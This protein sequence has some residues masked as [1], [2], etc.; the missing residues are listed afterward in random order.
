MASAY[1]SNTQHIDFESVLAMDDPEELKQQAVA[2]HIRWDRPCFSILFEGRLTSHCVIPAYTI[3]EVSRQRQYDD[4]LLSSLSV[5]GPFYRVSPRQSPVFSLR[6]SQFCTVFIDYSLFSRL[7]TEDI[8]HFVGSIALERTAL[9]SV[10][11][12]T[13]SADNQHVQLPSSLVFD[14][15][16]VQIEQSAAFAVTDEHMDID[17]SDDSS[18]HFDD[19]DA[20]AASISLPTSPIPD[21]TEDLNQLRAS[22]EHISERD[23]GAKNKDTLLLHL[24]YLERNLTTRLD[25]QDRV[26]GALRKDSNDQRSITSLEIKSSHKQLSTQIASNAL[27]VVDVRRV[28]RENHQ[29]LNAKITSL[30]EQ[31]AAT[32]HDFL[33]FSAQAQQTLNIITAQLSELVAYINRGGNDK[34]GEVSSSR[35]PPDDQNRGSGNTCGGGDIVRTTDIPQRDIDNAQRNILES[36]MSA[37]RAKER[38][39]RTVGLFG[40]IQ[41]MEEFSRSVVGLFS[42]VGLLRAGAF[43]KVKSTDSYF[44]ADG[45]SI[46]LIQSLLLLIVVTSSKGDTYSDQL[47]HIFWTLKPSA[48]AYL[49]EQPN[50]YDSCLH[51]HRNPSQADFVLRIPNRVLVTMFQALESS[52]LRNFLGCKAAI[53][54]EDIQ[55][56][57]DNT[58]VEGNTVTSTFR[59]SSMA[60]TEKM[61]AGFCKFRTEGLEVIS[62]FPDKLVAQMR[63]EFSESQELI[64]NDSKRN[65]LKLEYQFLHDIVGKTLT[66]TTGHVDVLTKI[67]LDMMVAIMGAVGAAADPDPVPGGAAEVSKFAPETFNT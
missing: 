7:P 57:F 15:P 52:G 49:S 21:V 41:Q 62:E 58:R 29:V 18:L 4:T 35:P 27:D 20:T 46:L 16:I 8:R 25:A 40:E 3:F 14:S 33:E 1:Y 54:E 55:I 24:H 6:V 2:H 23:D 31:V 50:G 11:I 22:I 45:Y 36:L 9:R 44:S 13:P 63:L 56:F 32:R 39:R 5:D 66:A 48:V 43:L 12:S 26:L 61:F 37:D 42:A 53:F 34:K 10:Q 17:P 64:H 38:E 47:V 65:D 19:N 60:I 30:D 28:V 67:R 59:G 51:P